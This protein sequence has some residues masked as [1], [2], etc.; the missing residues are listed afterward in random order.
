MRGTHNLSIART[1]DFS[2]YFECSTGRQQR[3]TSAM[4]SSASESKL[5]SIF[6]C[7]QWNVVGRSR[8]PRDAHSRVGTTSRCCGDGDPSGPS[9]INT[10]PH[11]KEGTEQRRETQEN[12]K[13][14]TFRPFISRIPR[15]LSVCATPN[16]ET[17]KTN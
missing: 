9:L 7:K 16:S 11:P 3:I 2:R 6:N 17:I 10:R 14:V 15:V 13:V 1:A 4:S 5:I 8:D 12:R